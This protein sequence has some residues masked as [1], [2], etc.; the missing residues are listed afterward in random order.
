MDDRSYVVVV[1][2]VPFALTVF[3]SA[4]LL[5]ASLLLLYVRC[6]AMMDE[7]QQGF[8]LWHDDAF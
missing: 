4:N 3:A 7:R 2:V 1:V 5:R 8:L 6:N